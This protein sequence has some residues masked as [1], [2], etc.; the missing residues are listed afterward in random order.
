MEAGTIRKARRRTL[1]L[2]REIER[3]ANHLRPFQ[4]SFKRQ[5]AR[6]WAAI[7]SPDTHRNPM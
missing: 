4:G 6:L 5:A 3:T 7:Y 1:F 2:I